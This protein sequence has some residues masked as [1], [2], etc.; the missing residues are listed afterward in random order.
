M[1]SINM[2]DCR[3]C[4][5]NKIKIQAVASIAVPI[6]RGDAPYNFSLE[7]IEEAYSSAA[8]ILAHLGPLLIRC[9]E[10]YEVVEGTL[11]SEAA[12]YFRT[13]TQ[14]LLRRDDI[15]ETMRGLVQFNELAIE[16][17]SKRAMERD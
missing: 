15:S 13:L 4:K 2:M 16:I 6:Q 11:F 14:T 17:V 8:Q 10:P 5:E 3:D 9:N 12:S 7:Q 1:A